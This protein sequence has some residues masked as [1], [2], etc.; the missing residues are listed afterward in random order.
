MPSKVPVRARRP[1]PLPHGSQSSGNRDPH[2]IR[3]RG[4]GAMVPFHVQS[5]TGFSGLV[6]PSLRCT[7]AGL[8]RTAEAGRR[9]LSELPP[10]GRDWGWGL[11]MSSCCPLTVPTFL[12]ECPT[13]S[14]TL[15]ALALSSPACC[16]RDRFSLPCG[17][18]TYQ[19]SRLLPKSV[20]V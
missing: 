9:H 11:R 20:S 12:P 7:S 15:P 6:C 2:T 1:L 14:R 17:D 4:Q 5:P 18:S 10:P 13:P 19:E 8:R 16:S 3:A